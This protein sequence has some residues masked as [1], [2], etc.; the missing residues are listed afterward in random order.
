MRRSL[1]ALA[2]SGLAVLA[3]VALS[4]C[5]RRA[6]RADCEAI[7]DKNVE[8]KLKADGIT[9]TTLVLKRKDELRA[10]LKDDLDKCVG[11]RITDS[12]L[13]CVAAAQT[14]ENIDKCLR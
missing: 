4:G 7:V 10:M 11:K 14:A 1:R 3:V 6:T 8:V 9:D 2:F 13:A 5:G 12:M